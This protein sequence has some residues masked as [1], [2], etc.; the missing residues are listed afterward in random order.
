MK[1][2]LVV[3]LFALVMPILLAVGSTGL[4]EEP[5]VVEIEGRQAKVT[6]V[7]G[8]AE[9]SRKEPELRRLLSQGDLLRHG[10]C[11]TTGDK[12][13]LELAMPDGSFLRFDEKTT[14]ELISVDY[15]EEARKRE[16]EVHSALG[17]TWAKVA[18]LV[19]GGGRFQ[20]S[21]KNAVAGVRG[22]TFRMNVNPDTSVVV[23]VYWGDIHVSSPPQKADRPTVVAKPEKVEGP[24][25][26]EG[27][28]PVSMQEWTYI[29][30]AMQQIVVLP[31]GT[32][33]KPFRF[34]PE[35]DAD[36]WVRWNQMRDRMQR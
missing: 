17:K 33:T 9:L 32:V 6:L 14:F 36:D 12:A 16:I 4:A 24:H 7:E 19:G 20:V 31:D 1:H 25:P 27:P 2:K 13:R 21:A 10:D 3:I 35:V 28:R 23:K 8:R 11:V 34:D 29:V 22:T 18:N 30:R 15:K 26:V 5:E